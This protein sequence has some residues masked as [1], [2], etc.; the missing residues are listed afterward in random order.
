MAAGI[1]WEGIRRS[2]IAACLII[3]VVAGALALTAGFQKITLRY[4]DGRTETFAYG[5]APYVV[6]GA[7]TITVHFLKD[8]QTIPRTALRLICHDACPDNL[9]PVAQDTILW[10]AR[11]PLETKGKVESDAAFGYLQNGKAPVKNASFDRV[12]Y[13]QFSE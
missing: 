8:K 5:L 10:E 9:A 11:K 6:I 7:D 2:F 3:P 12:R 4:K 1:D 13:I